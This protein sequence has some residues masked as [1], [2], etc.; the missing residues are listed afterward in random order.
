MEYNFE[1]V[2]ERKTI[3]ERIEKIEENIRML[4]KKMDQ[5]EKMRTPKQLQITKNPKQSQTNTHQVDLDEEPFI[6]A[7]PTGK[8]LQY[9]KKLI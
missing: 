2:L 3:T 1:I 9:I 5:L 8:L 6:L 7:T 4:V